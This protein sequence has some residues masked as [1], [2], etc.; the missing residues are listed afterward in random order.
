MTR[1][2]PISSLVCQKFLPALRCLAICSAYFVRAKSLFVWTSFIA[3]DSATRIKLSTR[4]TSDE[5]KPSVLTKALVTF[6]CICRNVTGVRV[7]VLDNLF[8]TGDENN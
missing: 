7:I 1:D 5:P 3:K 4:S 2:K 8:E 6:F